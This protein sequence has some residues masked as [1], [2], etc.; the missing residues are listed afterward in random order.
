MFLVANLMMWILI[1][2]NSNTTCTYEY[3]QYTVCP[4]KK[5]AVEIA[6]V[7]TLNTV[8]NVIKCIV[9]TSFNIIEHSRVLT[10]FLRS[11]V[12]IVLNMFYALPNLLEHIV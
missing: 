11:N 3:I 7:L 6:I 1:A 8:L 4:R 12:L 5:C 9:F 10:A 2:I